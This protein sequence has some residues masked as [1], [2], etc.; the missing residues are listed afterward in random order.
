[1]SR[2]ISSCCTLW[3]FPLAVAAFA[4]QPGYIGAGGCASSNCHGATSA[5]SEADSRI[6]GNEYSIW[7]VNDKH[8]Q[9][10]KVL[11]EPRSKRMAQI[12]GIADPTSDK[13]CTSCHVKVFKMKKG[14]TGPLTMAKMNAGEQCGAC[15]TG[16]PSAE[17]KTTFAVTD[18]ANCEKCH[19]K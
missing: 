17:G 9:A 4:Q 19:K 10:Y 14:Q 7:A 11:L 3:I 2:S 18:K 12:L 1:M 5:A 13:K 8:S 15:H 16:K 6:L